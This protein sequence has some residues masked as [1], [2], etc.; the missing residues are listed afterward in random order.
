MGASGARRSFQIAAFNLPGTRL[1]HRAVCAAAEKETR[2]WKEAVSWDHA[3]AWQS[4]HA[5]CSG[6]HLSTK[7]AHLKQPRRT[8]PCIVT[9][10]TVL[11]ATN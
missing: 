3:G 1:D 10:L 4:S 7:A 9:W 8:P 2:L 5:T 11:L 6:H